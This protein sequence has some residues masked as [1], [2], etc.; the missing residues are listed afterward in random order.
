MQ[1]IWNWHVVTFNNNLHTIWINNRWLRSSKISCL[2]IVVGELENLNGK[3][4][5]LT[6]CI[7]QSFG[8]TKINLIHLIAKE[9]HWECFL[10]LFTLNI[11]YQWKIRLEPSIVEIGVKEIILLYTAS[12]NITYSLDFFSYK[13]IQKEQ[14]RFKE[15]LVAYKSRPYL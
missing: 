10:H 15:I 9:L 13:L 6:A 7:G 4:F 8:N 2:L 1:I 3:F 14:M 5:T 11:P 12:K